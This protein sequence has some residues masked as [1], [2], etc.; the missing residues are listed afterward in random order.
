VCPTLPTTCAVAANTPAFGP[1]DDA[2]PRQLFGVL[3]C[4]TRTLHLAV[5][6]TSMPCIVSALQ[7]RLAASPDLQITIV[8]EDSMCARMGTAL[9][10]PLAMLDGNPRVT[11]VRDLR[12]G[13]LMHHKFV[14]ADGTRMWAG[15]ANFTEESFCSLSNNGLVLED[16]T[17]IAAYEAEFQ[18]MVMGQFGPIAPTAP[19]MGGNYTVHF[20]PRTPATSA[21][22]WFTALIA[23]INA[24][25][26][27]VEFEVYSFTRTEVSD[28]LIA[29]ARRGVAVRGVVSSITSGEGPS[30][31]LLAAMV[32]VREG[33]VHSKF[34]V[35]DGQLVFTGSPNWSENSWSNNE[36]S[37]QVRDMTVAAA[38]HAAFERAYAAGHAP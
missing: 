8:Y 24:A 36:A 22:P 23:A 13:A 35:I 25:T 29:A 34:A 14:I 7:A 16:A 12:T 11:L 28:A 38:Y 21:A 2:L 10:C 31:A 27:S 3:A 6:E 30:M 9:S 5:Y 1:E 19:A 32:P 18:R 17:I 33:R 4:A 37:L 20:S 26:T 15:S